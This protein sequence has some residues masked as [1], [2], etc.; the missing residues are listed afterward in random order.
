MSNFIDKVARKEIKPHNITDFI[1]QY[2]HNKD[3]NKAMPIFE[4]LGF[5]KK[6]WEEYEHDPS[7]LIEIIN[8][9]RLEHNLDL[10]KFY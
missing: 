3:I 10:E 4:F 6:Q 5:S 8:N 9:Y 1:E 2:Y 7:C